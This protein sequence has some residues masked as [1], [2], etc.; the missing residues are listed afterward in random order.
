MKVTKFG[1]CLIVVESNEILF[2]ILATL[3]DNQLI[4]IQLKR[5]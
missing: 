4:N 3:I 5:V 2:F 1:R